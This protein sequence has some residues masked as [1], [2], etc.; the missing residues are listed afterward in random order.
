MPLVVT[1]FYPLDVDHLVLKN[2]KAIIRIFGITEDR[3]RVIVL[4]HDFE[5]FFYIL[6]KENVDLEELKEFINGLVFPGKVVSKV[7][8]VKREKMKFLGEEVEVLKIFVNNPASIPKVIEELEKNEYIKAKFEN[9]ISFKRQYLMEKDLKILTKTR[10]IG[11]ELN[12]G[13]YKVDY[14]IEAKRIENL[15]GDTLQHFKI[16]AFDIEV[17]NYR[18]V[19][20]VTTDPITMISLASNY[21]LRKVILTK[22]FDGA[23][24]FVEFVDSEMELIKRFCEIVEE[25]APDLL[26]SY[27]GDLFDLPYLRGRATKYKISLEL[28]WTKTPLKFVRRGR[29]S[30]GKFNG[31]IHLDLYPFVLNL[32]SPTLKTEVYDLSS[33]AQE[34]LGEGKVEMDWE[35]IWKFWEEGGEKLRTLVEYSLR[36]STL[37]CKLGEKLLPQLV[38]LAKL[39]NLS[40]FDVSRMSYSQLAEAYLMKEVKNFRELIPN[41]PKKEE[42]QRRKEK[43]YLGAFVLQP[44]PGFYEDVVVFDFKSLYPTIIVTHNICPS[45]LNCG[46]CKGNGI[47]TP[48]ILR[49]DGK[50]VKYWFCKRKKGFVPSI[51]NELIFRRGRI[52]EMLKSISVD[53]PDYKILKARDYALK[54]ITNATYGYLGFPRARWYCLE[55]AE[56]ITAFGRKYITEIMNEVWNSGFKVIYGDTDSIMLSFKGKSKKEVLEFLRKINDKLPGIMELELRG[57]FPAGIW[58]SKKGEVERGAKKKYALI[59]EDGRIIIRGFEYVRR[60]WANIAKETQHE[61][62]KA[63]LRDRD[64]KKA[65]SIVQK[66]IRE[67]KEHKVPLEDVVIYTQLTKE[68]EE[69]EG[70][71]PHVMAAKRAKDKGYWVEPGSIIKWIVTDVPGKISDKA[72]P[73]QEVKEKGLKY[74]PEYYINHQLLPAVQRILEVLGFGKEEILSRKQEKL[75]KFF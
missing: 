19:P 13:R 63:V 73:Y 60:D 64:P 42:I 22:K 29:L 24:E 26:L 3:K 37:V 55:C 2:G 68:F 59:D 45:T 23:Q 11:E 50:K 17:H 36:D 10:V 67:L 47:E 34:L 20:R 32:L 70:L 39:V 49:S 33:V 75:G 41:R 46:C 65:L 66:K 62:L 9:D 15:D 57:F 51:L 52:K 25:E 72:Y 48:E 74:D 16:L 28:G 18:G 8:K 7:T 61:V 53:D 44:S 69:Y 71:G 27:N 4:D 30:A 40:L 12:P 14:L 6:P 38:E 35:E 21:G 43:T 58:V 5:P 31:L 56:S 54:T 1:E